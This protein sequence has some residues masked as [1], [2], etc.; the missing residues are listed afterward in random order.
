MN[1]FLRKDQELYCLCELSQPLVDR[2]KRIIN[3]TQCEVV[4]S[5]SWRFDDCIDR[6]MEHCEIP[7]IDSTGIS[8]CRGQEIKDW[9]EMQE[10]PYTY[11]IL[12]DSE[13][14]LDTQ[15]SNTIWTSSIY[16]ISEDQVQQAINILNE[17]TSSINGSRH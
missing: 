10:E 2:V 11:C 4:L 3:A 9:L 7:Y 15:E 14:L 5:T 6:I 12:E 1:G 13:E 17:E 8:S 16:G